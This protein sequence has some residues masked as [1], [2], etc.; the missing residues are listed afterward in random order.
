MIL[1]IRDNCEHPYVLTRSSFLIHKELLVSLLKNKFRVDES[2][3]EVCKQE[4][5]LRQKIYMKNVKYV[6]LLSLCYRKID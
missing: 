1:G 4:F 3:L 5:I 6:P 2:V